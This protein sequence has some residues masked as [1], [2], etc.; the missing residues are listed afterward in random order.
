[1]CFSIKLQ[2]LNYALITYEGPYMSPKLL[3]SVELLA[4]TSC[5][6]N[7]LM[8][9]TAYLLSMRKFLMDLQPY[10][11]LW[12]TVFRLKISKIARCCLTSI[13][14]NDKSMKFNNTLEYLWVTLNS[15]LTFLPHLHKKR[16]K[17]KQITKNLLK[18]SATQSG[19]R[20]KILNFW[21][22]KLLPM[23]LQ[24]GSQNYKNHTAVDIC[25]P[26][27]LSAY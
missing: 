13:K 17:I 24:L 16:T 6:I 10:L 1:M 23:P 18:F 2:Y 15:T 8:L 27:K 25:H 11:L 12:P 3:N 21:Y 26:Y 20:K 7:L 19:S 5:L 4:A 9:E 22:K 14:L